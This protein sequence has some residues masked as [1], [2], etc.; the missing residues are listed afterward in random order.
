MSSRSAIFMTLLVI[1]VILAGRFLIPD[2]PVRHDRK[3]V[4]ETATSPS[5]PGA[6]P[7][8]IPLRSKPEPKPASPLP[9]PARTEHLNRAGLQLTITFDPQSAVF[10][11][12]LENK[13]PVRVRG[14]IVE[15]QLND[16]TLLRQ[17]MEGELQPGSLTQ[18]RLAAGQMEV[19]DWK[20]RVIWD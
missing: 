6:H 20:P 2:P 15:I 10:S 9:D 1:V 16:G 12:Q 3:P 19:L 7:S 14:V 13:T 8:P 5:G 11:G 4:P 17:P 18:V